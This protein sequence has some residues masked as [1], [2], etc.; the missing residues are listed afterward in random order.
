[1]LISLLEDLRHALRALKRNPGFTAVVGITLAL[2]IGGNTTIFSVLKASLFAGLPYPEP[3]R[4]LALDLTQI[5]PNGQQ[6]SWDSWSFPKYET[7][8]Q[9]VT[10]IELIAA[11]RGSEVILAG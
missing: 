1:M 3:D 2:G 7:M 10:T 4:L 6:E 11:R 9:N 5:N 8:L